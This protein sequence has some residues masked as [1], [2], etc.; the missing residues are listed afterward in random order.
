MKSYLTKPRVQQAI[1]KASRFGPVRRNILDQIIAQEA[2]TEQQKRLWALNQA[3]KN[4]Y[5]NQALKE[6][7]KRF[8]AQYSQRG[9]WSDYLGDRENIGMG[10]AAAD[11]AL[12]GLFGYQNMQRD[13]EYAKKRDAI[14]QKWAD[15]LGV[16]L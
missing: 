11:T 13:K 7:D 9:S 15:A 16:E 14:N 1:Q 2:D 5:R 10:I 4:Y 8:N 6:Q 12:N 3:S